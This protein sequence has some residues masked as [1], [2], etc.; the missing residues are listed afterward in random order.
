MTSNFQA[1]KPREVSPGFIIYLVLAGGVQAQQNVLLSL[2]IP[3]PLPGLCGQWRRLLSRSGNQNAQGFLFRGL[4][5]GASQGTMAAGR[6][7]NVSWG[8]LADGNFPSVS[9][10][11]VCPAITRTMCQRR[12][13]TALGPQQPQVGHGMAPVAPWAL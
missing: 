7:P 10:G 3:K 11:P 2:F 6:L 9:Q 13:A 12:V 1:A 4:G 8:T 5:T